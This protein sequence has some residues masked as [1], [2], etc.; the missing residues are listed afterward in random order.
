M[1][2]FLASI[3]YIFVR[4]TAILSKQNTYITKQNQAYALQPKAIVYMGNRNLS[5]SPLI[6]SITRVKNNHFKRK[7]DF[8]DR[9]PISVNKG[10][11][12]GFQLECTP[13]TSLL[14]ASEQKKTPQKPHS[15]LHTN[16]I[17]VKVC[18]TYL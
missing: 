10:T 15:L 12:Q 1:E 4:Q 6:A 13:S 9:D 7:Q 2:V 5:G 8:Q 3:Q 14:V 18:S 17:L 11:T 16:S